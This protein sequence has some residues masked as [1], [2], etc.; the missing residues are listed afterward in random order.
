MLDMVT[1][2]DSTKAE[3][4][5]A[6][7]GKL[8][9]AQV[10]PQVLFDMRTWE[11][12]PSV[13]LA[14]IS[15]VFESDTCLIVRSSALDEDAAGRS[16]AGHYCSV[17]NVKGD[18][19]LSA[20]IDRVCASY[21]GRSGQD[22]IFVQPM[23]QEI[24]FSGVAF[25]SEPSTGAPCLVFNYHDCSTDTTA[26]TAGQSNDLH[27]WH[28]YLHENPV[29]PE[30]RFAGLV[31]LVRELQA[32][33]PQTALDLEVAYT[34]AGQWVLFQVRSLKI[35][36][37]FAPERQFRGMQ[38]VAQFLKPMQ[39]PHPFLYGQRTV[40][41]VMPDWNPAEIIGIRPRPLARTLYQELITD[42]IWAYQRDNYGYRNLR[43][44][45][46]M[47][48]LGGC[49]YIDVRV[50]FN[51]FIPAD[52]PSELAEKLVNDSIQR[53]LESPDFHDKVE[54]E[55]LFSCYTLD[56]PA[57]LKLLQNRGFSQ[58][59][60][61]LLAESL[62][63]LTNRILHQETG[64]WKKDIARLKILETRR[65]E[66][67]A[68]DLG[69]LDRIYWLL[70]DC[71]RYGTLPFA[72]LARAGFIAV[73]MLN[74]LVQ[75]GV[76]SLNERACYMQSLDTVS[77]RIQRDYYRLSRPA[78]LEIYGHLRPGTYDILSERYDRAPERY[79]GTP[80]EPQA[81]PVFSLSLEQLKQ[82]RQLLQSHG[83]ELDVL[84]LF[85]FI[86]AAIEGREYAKFLFTRN[87]S[88]VLEAI[89]GL[90]GEY[91]LS[92]ED[93]SFLDIQAL[94]RRVGSSYDLDWAL[95]TLVEAG[96]QQDLLTR[97]LVLPPL[98]TRPEDIWQFEYLPGEPNFVT[99]KR[100]KGPVRFA[101]ASPESLGGAI[102]LI[103][104]ADPGYDWIFGYGIAGLITLYGG[105]NS[106]MAIRAG[107]MGIPAVIGA[108]EVLYQQWQKA[109][110]LELD[111]ASR[112]VMVLA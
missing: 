2:L 89:A 53:L 75:T 47:V 72:G 60:C 104:S 63:Q 68:S 18:Q 39:S 41:G 76:L 70:E 85:D 56:L 35:S 44:F 64:L 23:L 51:S 1:I 88:D 79:F 95:K 83:L 49:P 48:S 12:E 14:R 81:S 5:A 57:R 90:G 66:L 38:Q 112:Q 19:A 99:L 33:F 32:I 31:A 87:L 101:D 100:A 36:A 46:L 6:L 82:I 4:L 58:L 9:S 37:Q 20:A 61:D 28:Y 27:T 84:E 24:A 97:S 77:S 21:Q 103:P 93:C 45:P 59:E 96:R 86:K 69:G 11:T 10:L 67:L 91:G 54:F 40:Y 52:L 25:S 105:V 94:L 108:G 65:K 43:S 78:F 26:V 16:L 50:S 22:Q 106:H 73:Q 110:E 98:I 42:S 17:L 111:C 71:K 13:V 7:H 102:L 34:H 3:S 62:R 30:V 109:R 29:E 8:H 92:R 15:A 107:E 80:V 55:I 74:S